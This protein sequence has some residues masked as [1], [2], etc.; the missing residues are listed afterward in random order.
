MTDAQVSPSEIV[1]LACPY[2]DPEPDVRED[3][4]RCANKAAA[5]L[6]EQGLIVYSPIS[7]THPIDLVLAAEGETKGPEYWVP[8]DEAF[9]TV[10]S[11]MIILKLDGWEKSIGVQRETEWFKRRGRPVEYLEWAEVEAAHAL[12]GGK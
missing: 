12:R 11:R 6:V 10:C 1:Y 2:T 8:F 9:M 5:H 7:M 4:F 3:R